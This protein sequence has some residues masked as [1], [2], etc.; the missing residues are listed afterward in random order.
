[1]EWIWEIGNLGLKRD[2]ERV[3]ID[4][5]RKGERKSCCG[6]LCCCQENYRTEDVLRRES[7]KLR[8]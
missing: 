5:G 7:G 4:K 6:Y 8:D 1:M 3:S 2:L